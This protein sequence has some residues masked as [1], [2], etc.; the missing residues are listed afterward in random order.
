MPLLTT[1]TRCWLTRSAKP[2]TFTGEYDNILPY[3]DC[4]RMGLY[5]HI[6][7]CRSLCGFCP[8]CK[9]QYTQQ[10]CESY[11]RHLIQEIGLVGGAYPDKKKVTSLY[12]GGGSPALALPYLGE[13]L[14][15]LSQYFV[16]TEGIGMELHPAD[17]TPAVLQALKAAGVTKLSIGIQ[18]FQPKYQRILGRAPVSPDML[19]DVLE[20]IPFETVSMDLIFALPG[21]TIEDLRADMDLAFSHGA[22]HVAVYPFIDFTF[23]ESHTPAMGR[24]EKRRLLDGVTAHCR[25]KGYQRTSIWTFAKGGAAYSSMTRETFL[26][27]GCSAATLLGGQF[28][29]NT[30]DIAAYEGRIAAGQL[31]TALT[32]RFTPRQR[33]VYY[34]FWEAYGMEVRAENFRRF[35]GVPLRRMYGME[36]ALCRALGFA[37]YKDGRYTLTDKGAFYY[38]HYENYY[39]LAY[40]DKMWGTLGR[41]PFPGRMTL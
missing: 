32:I 20:Q 28:K 26:G 35:F 30:F 24:R 4:E 14:E 15:A 19:A 23:T 12:F 5:V 37:R 16:I 9:V 22:N 34:L 13:I 36:L 3:G 29:V 17:V 21:Q 27:F 2:F 18:S 41:V 7:F 31:P 25:E 38:H 8:Y 10:A 6:P 1:L 33:M 39:T 11:I 40:I